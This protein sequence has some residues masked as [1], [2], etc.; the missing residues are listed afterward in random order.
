ML[1]RFVESMSESC[2]FCT[3]HFGERGGVPLAKEFGS[4]TE[5]DDG[6][7]HSVAL[8]RYRRS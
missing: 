8:H 4:K 7:K 1:S 5:C 3:H 2:D 6:I